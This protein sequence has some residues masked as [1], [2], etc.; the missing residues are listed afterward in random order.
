MRLLLPSLLE[1]VGGD[2]C[3]EGLF[4]AND[5]TGSD[6]RRNVPEPS[7]GGCG[8]GCTEE[9]QAEASDP[10]EILARG[11]NGEAKTATDQE[12]SACGQGDANGKERG[13]GVDAPGKVPEWFHGK[14]VE[15]SARDGRLRGRLASLDGGDGGGEEDALEQRGGCERPEAGGPLPGVQCDAGDDIHG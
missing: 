9:D 13:G 15:P 1:R 7:G 2:G 5:E 6:E 8:E 4:E 11:A 12:V 3:F 10:G 14:T